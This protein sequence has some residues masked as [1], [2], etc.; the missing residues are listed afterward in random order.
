MVCFLKRTEYSAQDKNKNSR[1][2]VL[3]DKVIRG[4]TP[5]P[6]CKYPGRLFRGT[7]TWVS[8][9]LPGDKWERR[10]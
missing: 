8:V 5:N 4:G 7:A 6:S 10:E 3:L 2:F 1:L 9:G